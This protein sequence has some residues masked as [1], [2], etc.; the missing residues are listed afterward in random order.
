MKIPTMRA[1]W[2][3]IVLATC[4]LATV[5]AQATPDTGVIVYGF[6]QHEPAGAWTIV[7]P[8]SFE[9]GGVRT[10]V[11]QLQGKASRWSQFLDR[12]VAVRGRV[13]LVAAGP[14]RDFLAIVVEEMKEVEPPGTARKRLDRDLTLHAEITLAVIPNR[15]AWNDRSGRPTGVN[16]VLLYSIQNQRQAP[17]AFRLPTNDLLCVTVLTDEGV[18][19]WEHTTQARPPD[20]RVF[21]VTR[22]GAYRDAVQLPQVAAAKPGRYVA[23]VGVCQVDGYDITVEFEVY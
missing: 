17:I 10:F 15:I 5:A 16:P 22:G 11:L 20:P 4:S 21:V 9:V 1:A 23:R 13:P 3:V 6:L 12:Y 19:R 2:S 14:A 7:V 8:Q 18:T